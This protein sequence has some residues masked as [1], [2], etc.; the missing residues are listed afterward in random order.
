M[1]L[2]TALFTAFAG[3]LLATVFELHPTWMAMLL[4]TAVLFIVV[5]GAGTVGWG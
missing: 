2:C 1:A 4:T 3:A 5:E